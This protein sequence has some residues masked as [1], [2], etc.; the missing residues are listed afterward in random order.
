MNSTAQKPPSTETGRSVILIA[1][2]AA[3]AGFLFGY[4]SAVINGATEAIRSQFD[5]GPGPLGFAVASALVGA[6]IGA[7][8]GGSISDR[9]GRIAVMKIAAVLFLVSALGSGLAPEIY[10][11]IIFRVIGGVGMGI[12]S[13][14]A[15]AYI[16]E[17][18]PAHIRGRLG[19]LQQFAIVVGIFLSQLVNK[20]LADAAGGSGADL[21]FGMEA[22]RWMLLVE[23][24]PALGYFV[25]A[26]LIPESPRYLVATHKIPE[27]RRVLTLI[28]G[29]KNLEISF[30][31]IKESLER[32]EKPSLKDIRGAAAGLKPI[33]WVGIALA[34]FQQFVGINVVFY[35]SNTLW[36][37]V[38]FSESQSFIFSLISATINVTVT[39]FAILLVDKVGRKP[40]LLVGSIGM[41]LTLGTMAVV[42]AMAPVTDAGP[43]LEGAAGPIALVCANL[44]VVFFGVSWGPVMWVMLGEMFPNR[45]RGAAL[46]VAGFAQWFAN[47]LVTQTFPPLAAYSLG[48]AYGLYAAFAAISFL[49]VAKFVPET[50]G[51]ELEDMTE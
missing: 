49:F 7:F 5:V 43:V 51:R 11:L 24:L 6:A 47:F 32:E 26:Y 17:I 3:L 4:D 44:F 37:S 21:W 8:A 40:L 14:I 34:I 22:W 31:R 2:V 12:A 46:A 1:S 29:Q 39:I 20:L 15:P 35:Y 28:L 16:A 19:S 50:N 42:F 10:T 9:I 36:Q 45:F 33:V 27:A 38:G 30:N 13:V 18:A 48:L 41:A 23:A 25:G